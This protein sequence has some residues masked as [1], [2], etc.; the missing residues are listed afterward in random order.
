MEIWYD[1]ATMEVKAVYSDTYTGNVWA[2][3][4]YLSHRSP[5]ALTGDLLPGAVIEF[6]QDGEPV[7]V[8]PAPPPVP[9]VPTAR[10]LREAELVAKFRTRT[11]TLPE[12]QEYL[13]SRGI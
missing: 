13:V 12:I 5:A 9:P 6:D 11:A 10:E 8:T 7:V 2:D 3:A 1:L 4:G